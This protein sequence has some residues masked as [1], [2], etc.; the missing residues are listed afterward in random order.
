MKN[1]APICLEVDIDMELRLPVDKASLCQLIRH[2][3]PSG[4]FRDCPTRQLHHHG[5]RNDHGLSRIRTE[6]YRGR[7]G[8]TGPQN[9]AA[10]DRR[11][12][13]RPNYLAKLPAG[14]RRGDR[15]KLPTYHQAQTA[16]RLKCSTRS[17]RPPSAAPE[18]N[19]RVLRAATRNTAGKFIANRGVP[20]L[21]QPRSRRGRSF[22]T[23]SL[24][25]I[26]K[27]HLRPNP[28]YSSDSSPD[29]SPGMSFPEM[30]EMVRGVTRHAPRHPILSHEAER[31]RSST[32]AKP[33]NPRLATNRPTEA[34]VHPRRSLERARSAM[35]SIVL[36]HGSGRVARSSKFQPK[37]QNKTLHKTSRSRQCGANSNSSEPAITETGISGRR[38]AVGDC[39]IALSFA[40]RETQPDQADPAS[41]D[42]TSAT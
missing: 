22:E 14:R 6:R 23:H 20:A 36:P 3:R 30:P 7:R 28:K 10:H 17:R 24:Q 26:P 21:S 16:S 31:L 32:R 40:D 5:L 38:L 42:K 37:L 19:T 33:K 35:D 13:G 11:R 39:A 34:G 29:S 25:S 27:T 9:F 2:S 41:L 4:D 12:N 1:P 18:Q 8:K 15:A